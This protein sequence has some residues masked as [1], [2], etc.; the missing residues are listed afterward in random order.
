M[1]FLLTDHAKQRMEERGIPHPSQLILKPAG[2]AI[3]RRIRETCERAGVKNE[4]GS[5]YVYFTNSGRFVV[6]VFVCKVEGVAKYRVITAF[7]LK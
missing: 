5:D 6:N 3:R 7:V 4:W 1:D 2:A